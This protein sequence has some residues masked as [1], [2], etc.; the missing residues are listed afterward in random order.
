MIAKGEAMRI[1]FTGTGDGRGIPAVGCKCKL[2]IRAREEG[3]KNHRR[4]VSILLRN[5]TETILYDTPPT[6]GE[7]INRER[8][9]NITAIFLSHKHFDH[10]GGNDIVKEKTNATVIAHKSIMAGIAD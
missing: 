10:I 1:K 9:F 4:R 7:M 2:C 6:I 5:G 8:I 3:G